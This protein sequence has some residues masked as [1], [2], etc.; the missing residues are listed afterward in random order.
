MPTLNKIGTALSRSHHTPPADPALRRLRIAL[1]VFFAVDGFLFA[2]WVVR[3]PAIKAQVGASAGQLGLALLGVSAGAV[4]TMLLTG[5]LCRVF[6]SDRVTVA[7]G[8]MLSFSIAL[9]PRT[10]SALA[11]GLVL[12]CF[13]I[14][15]GGLNVAMNSVAVDLVA[16]LRRPVMSSFHA[17]YSLGGLL[18]SAT[19]GLLAPH[20]SPATHLLLLTPV[21]LLAVV[22]AGRVLLAQPLRRPGAEPV[23]AAAGPSAPASPTVRSKAAAT[24]TA[25]AGSRRDAP[26]RAATTT[27]N[28]SRTGV[29][30]A[31]FGLIAACTAYGEGA[32]AEWGPL[33]IQQ[34]LHAGPGIA[35]A[36][37][38]AVT[39][40]MTLGRLSGTALLERL[41][42]TRALI[43]GGLTACAGMLVAA[44]TPYLA[45][46]MAGFALTGLGLANLF[47]TAIARA[48]ELTG[49]SGVAAASTLGYGGMLLGPPSIGFLTDAFGLP[50]ALTTVAALAAVAAVI[51]YSVRNSGVRQAG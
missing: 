2:G 51:A 5:R 27:A 46:V 16:A 39:L 38:S 8:V 29:L 44:L 12:L 26:A 10:H 18:G 9:P 43:L 50:T 45:L 21:G 47:P 30:V 24:A 13:G 15:Y 3:I 6:G 1:T 42:Q 17:A 41:G 4:A 23:P 40:A 32:L 49:P 7:T 14:S 35:A 28:G 37:Y 48:G 19:G 34:D 36:G 31:V 11:L 33:H 25:R 22:L 20:L